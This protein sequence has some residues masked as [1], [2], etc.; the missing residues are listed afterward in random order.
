MVPSSSSSDEHPAVGTCPPE[1]MSET[2]TNTKDSSLDKPA[3]KRSFNMSWTV[4]VGGAILALAAGMVNSVSFYALNSFSSHM[5][6]FITKVGLGLEDDDQADAGHNVL[7]IA[8]FVL[9]SV[10]TGFW[11][12]KQHLHFDVA[13]YDM[14][15]LTESILLISATLAHKHKLGIYLSAAA[16][17]L[18][19]GMTTHWGTAALRTTHVTGLFTD[20]GLLSG[21]VLSLLCWKR[22]GSNFDSADQSSFEDDVSKLSVLLTLACC[23]T[24]GVYIGGHLYN[25][26][27]ELAFVVPAVITGFMGLLFMYY[28]VVVLRNKLFLGNNEVTELRT[29]TVGEVKHEHPAGTN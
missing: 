29:V 10:F 22:C 19:N 25:A 16:C 11:L 15:L 26:A 28:R 27:D 23:F 3:P 21:K 20:V 12:A 9:G 24:A 4:R 17:G 1:A 5:T 7:A 18:Q 13:L 2:K 6:G 14:C 8:S